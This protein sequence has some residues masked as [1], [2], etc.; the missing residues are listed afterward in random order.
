MHP[1]E[2][3]SSDP[4]TA[5]TREDCVSWTHAIIRRTVEA[6][7]GKRGE[8]DE[9]LES[10]VIEL[11]RERGVDPTNPEE[12]R[13][14]EQKINIRDL[15]EGLRARIGETLAPQGQP[16][17]PETPA[18]QPATITQ[19]TKGQILAGFSPVA[20]ISKRIAV[21]LL[22]N[23]EG[24]AIQTLF[25]T[26]DIPKKLI[27]ANISGTNKKHFAPFN[28]KAVR[29]KN[30]FSIIP[31]YAQATAPEQPPT[32]TDTLPPELPAPPVPIATPAE[33]TPPEPQSPTESPEQS[34]ETI[35]AK[36]RADALALLSKARQMLEAATATAPET[37]AIRAGLF[38]E[39]EKLSREQG[40]AQ[41][42]HYQ[43]ITLN[44]LGNKELPIEEKAET[45][46][47]LSKTF[48]LGLA[49]VVLELLRDYLQK[50]YARDPTDST[51]TA[52]DKTVNK[53]AQTKGL[54]SQNTEREEAYFVEILTN[55]PSA[56]E[57]RREIALIS[58]AYIFKR[59]GEYTK[60]LEYAQEKLK[61]EQKRAEQT[62]EDEINITFATRSSVLKLERMARG[63]KSPDGKLPEIE[64]FE[65][66][67]EHP[68]LD[69]RY[70]LKALLKLAMLYRQSDLQQTC[71][72]GFEALRLQL[73]HADTAATG[74]FS[75]V[76]KILNRVAKSS[77]L[78]SSDDDET[79]AAP[80]QPDGM[81]E[82][83]PGQPQPRAE[84][85]PPT[86]PPTP[87]PAPELPPQLP[88]A[89]EQPAPTPRPPA[90][91]QES[92]EAQRSG[93]LE[94]AI[95]IM[96]RF[97]STQ[98][99]LEVD[100]ELILRSDQRIRNLKLA[101]QI[102]RDGQPA[103]NRLNRNE[104]P[105][106]ARLLREANHTELANQCDGFT[107]PSRSAATPSSSSSS[108]PAT[109]P[110][111][112]SP[113]S[114]EEAPDIYSIII[115][116]IERVETLSKKWQI[117]DGYLLVPNTRQGELQKELQGRLEA[118]HASEDIAALYARNNSLYQ[119]VNNKLIP[120]L[121]V[122]KIRVGMIQQFRRTLEALQP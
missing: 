70:R 90:S 48:T 44:V 100:R 59:R 118:I 9:R 18:L 46:F 67:L 60:A 36:T 25:E 40:K 120:D 17:A 80:A 23:P 93:D 96:E 49:T 6:V 81:S 119:M 94:L 77:R 33:P 117:K 109:I 74:S 21:A 61:L 83:V 92:I 34:P 5:L 106:I 35:A 56:P 69:V 71:K 14:P 64:F 104:R 97:L 62:P 86:E 105:H 108:A 107:T 2:A 55:N 99:K 114:P 50:E 51:K 88:P 116:W 45:I 121:R 78:M 16:P 29:R 22:D 82:T 54:M 38:R 42:P 28:L 3:S 31:L 91:L 24:I 7:T 68:E 84:S 41:I 8:R 112:H 63:D 76:L 102:V 32:S 113:P 72:Y 85:L 103:I 39:G 87:P 98:E 89:P 101:L 75:E 37:L 111:P 53:I 66:A 15:A 30:I 27:A 57:D 122:G 52:L 26:L 110:V 73:E 1:P 43:Q 79:A 47:E 65:K 20:V 19:E 11:I 115:S 13:H 58:L 4:K 12:R 95:E 10:I